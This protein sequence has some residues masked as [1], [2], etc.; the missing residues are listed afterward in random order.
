M[1]QNILP[2]QDVW[3]EYGGKWGELA[4]NGWIQVWLACGRLDP[5]MA[6]PRKAG[7]M[8]VWLARGKLDP[9]MAGPQKAGSR[10]GWPSNGSKSGLAASKSGPAA[11][12]S[13]PAASKSGPAAAMAPAVATDVEAARPDFEAGGGGFSKPGC[14]SCGAPFGENLPRNPTFGISKLGF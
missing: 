7:S 12:K 11:L 3:G 6:G 9:G 1:A 2:R 13:G 5:G 10:Y 14:Y 4:G 8:Q